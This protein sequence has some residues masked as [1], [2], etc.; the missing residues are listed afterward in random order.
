LPYRL[1]RFAAFTRGRFSAIIGSYIQ[2]GMNDLHTLT[3]C[4]DDWQLVINALRALSVQRIQ[5]AHN[6]GPDGV[7]GSV[8]YDEAGT[9][10]AIASDIELKLP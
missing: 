1:G 4:S 6:V 9:M 8:L 10:Q 5:E 3:L 2:K 7:Y